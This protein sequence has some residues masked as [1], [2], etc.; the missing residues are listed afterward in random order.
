MFYIHF[1]LNLFILME[2]MYYYIHQI[3][4]IHFVFRRHENSLF[5]KKTNFCVKMS[6]CNHFYYTYW[7]LAL[8]VIE[9]L[10]TI[11][12][13][14]SSR[15]RQISIQMKIIFFFYF[16]QNSLER[17]QVFYINTQSIIHGKICEWLNIRFYS[18]A[19][20]LMLIETLFI[21]YL[22]TLF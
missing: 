10:S 5:K 11:F 6:F 16:Y 13:R 3:R 19:N 20:R 7:N 1:K 4:I 12:I 17:R 9:R 15:K 22:T 21:A 8:I 2:K 18:D 14:L